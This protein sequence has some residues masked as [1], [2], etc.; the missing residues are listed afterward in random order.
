L[1]TKIPTNS[2]LTES[3]TEQNPPSTGS[4]I[5]LLNNMV[6]L[7]AVSYVIGIICS[8][9]GLGGGE[10]FSPVILSYGVIPEVTSGTTATMS[11]FNAL[12]SSLRDIAK[13]T[14][15]PQLGAIIFGIGCCSG[16]TGRQLG[17]YIAAN[18]GRASVIVF[19]LS[20]GLYLSCLYYIY[21]LGFSHFDSE[22]HGFC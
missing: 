19:F 16:L 8:M 2:S 5:D 1:N 10:I 11:F 9:L 4:D 18:Y 3:L 14:I 20:L 7:T 15:E 13:G 22:V 6:T 12:T 17:L 21:K